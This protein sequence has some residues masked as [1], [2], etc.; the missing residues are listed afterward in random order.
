[1]SAFQALSKTVSAKGLFCALYADR[2][3][4]YNRT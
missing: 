3:S 4:H 2:A 1:M